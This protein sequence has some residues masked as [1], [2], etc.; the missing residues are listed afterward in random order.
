VAWYE[1]ETLVGLAPFYL[2]NGH[3]Q[4]CLRPVGGVEIADYLDILAPKG[5]EERIYQALIEHLASPEAPRWQEI[6]LINVPETTPTHR[7][8]P[9]LIQDAG[10]W[11]WTEVEDVCPIIPLPETFDAYLGMLKKKQRHEVRRKLR[12]LYQKAETVQHRTV[13]HLDELPDAMDMFLAL[14]RR[15][16]PEKA[17]FMTSRMEGFFRHIAAVALER[18]WLRL[19]FL[20]I[21]GQALATLFSFDYGQRRMV[22][23]SGFDPDAANELSPGWNLV[24]LEIQDAIERGLKVFDFLQ[25]N[26]EYKFRLGGQSTFVYRLHIRRS[27][28]ESMAEIFSQRVDAHT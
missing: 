23:N 5:Q 25:G 12:R 20:V 19:S 8:L 17:A 4:C 13:H 16:S 9:R 15:S 11:A 7:A 26:E 10:W 6:T 21:D 24:V 2:K 3:F 14:H 22:Y 18:D 28:P 1:D 27:P